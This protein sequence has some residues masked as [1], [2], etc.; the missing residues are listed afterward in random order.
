MYFLVGACHTAD[1]AYAVLCDLRD[2]RAAAIAAYHN[3]KLKHEVAQ[4][5]ARRWSPFKA[6]RLE[7][8]AE[9]NELDRASVTGDDLYRAAKSELAFIDLCIS[10]INP[11]RQFGHLLDAEAHQAAQ[12]EEWLLELVCRAENHLLTSGSVPADQFAAMRLHPN[13][14]DKIL[15]AIEN[16]RKL[17]IG[18]I[19]PRPGSDIAK[20]IGVFDNARIEKVSGK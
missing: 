8:E 7:R 14:T 1:G 5:R 12:S 2:D 19:A 20:L 15:P 9:L 13:F 16:I 17:G 4:M 18:A 3:S 6:T 10:R 11:H